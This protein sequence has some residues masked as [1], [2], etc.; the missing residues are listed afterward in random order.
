L[1]H[2]HFLKPR[3]VVRYDAEN[4][5]KIYPMKNKFLKNFLIALIFIV[6]IVLFL[7]TLN[8]ANETENWKFLGIDF[9]NKNDIIS[10][11]GSLIGGILSFLSILF[12]LV[13]LIQQQ[14]QIRNEKEDKIND[15]KLELLN[16]LK[17]LSSFFKSAINNIEL[18]GKEMKQF[19]EKEKEFPSTM[20]QMYFTTNKNF[21]RVIDLDSI[22]IYKAINYNFKD[23]DNW[24]K[25]FLNIYSIFDFYSEALKELKE[26][27]ES[28]I[29]FKVE[30]QRKI[31]YDIKR[32]V[33]LS[34]NLIDEYKI[35]TGGNYLEQPW[36]K[37]VNK[38]I[39]EY[40]KYLEECVQKN[41]IS[42]LRIISNDYLFPF[43]HNA[44]LI[45]KEFGYDNYGSRDLVNL[46]SDIRK[47]IN[48][49]EVNCI[50]YAENIEK[51]YN[52]YFSVENENSKQLLEYKKKFDELQN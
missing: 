24:E 34:A 10:S 38:F 23:D 11:Y 8:L 7:I 48:E 51:Q 27:Y 15:E 3:N 5:E 14:E 37:F 49:V 6:F 25:M 12:V 41:E 19:F 20:N 40:Y 31:S 26:K 42:N 35:N 13:S 4:H 32:L 47:R 1:V 33:N 50:H 9:N 30:E 28:Q 43:L 44:M 46:A 2:R 16:K 21:T 17:L 39:P 45:R 52:E 22:T 18:Q 36:A 29:N